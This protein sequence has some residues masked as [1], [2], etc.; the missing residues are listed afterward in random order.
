VAR[1]DQFYVEC[2][3][4]EHDI[5]EL[6][7]GGTGE[8]AFASQPKLTF[9]VRIR[10][11]DPIAEA[12]QT[13]N[14]VLARCAVEQPPADWWRPGMSGVAKLEAGRRSPG[15]ILTRRTVDYLRLHL[16]W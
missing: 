13:G 11:I 1:T 2:Q 9:P 8:I 15:W 3:V 4:S 16:W 7:T 10:Q 5:Q 14:V 6:H 12:K